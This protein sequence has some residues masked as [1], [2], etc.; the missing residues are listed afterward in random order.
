MR[1]LAFARWV[2]CHRALVAVVIAAITAFFVYQLRHLEVYSEFDDLLPP[3]HAYTA[4]HKKFREKFGGANAVTLAVVVNDGTVFTA[5]TVAKI[6]RITQ[7]VDRLPG[8]DHYHVESLTHRKIRKT[9]VGPG[10]WINT[11]PLVNES[12]L[13][14]TPEELD[15]L[16]ND[17]A[18]SI[19]YGT[20]VSPDFRAAVVTA[21]FHE[22]RI[23]YSG[24]FDGIQKIARDEGDPGHEIHVAGRPMLIGW[25]Y[26]YLPE[27]IYIALFSTAVIVILLLSYF[28]RI[29]GALIPMV[30][31][32]TS[33]IWGL[34][35]VALL[36]FNLDPLGLIVPILL[37][38][39][40][41]SHGVQF[42]ERYFEEYDRLKDVREASTVT[43]A[44]M[45]RPGV[46]GILTDA[47]GILF[48]AVS[49]I[50][51]MVK[52][53]YYCAFLSMSIIVTVLIQAPLLLSV[54]PPPRGN[55]LE[56]KKLTR[57]V[58]TWI[59]SLSAGRGRWATVVV[60]VV[61]AVVSAFYSRHLVIGDV[62][63]GSP[64]LRA[65]SAYNTAE[66]KINER[67]PGSD[68]LFII[69][70]GEKNEVIKE[71]A[72]LKKI[73]EFQQFMELDP[74]AGGSKAL[75]LIV[76]VVNRVLHNND[77]KW[78]RLPPDAYNV[79]GL[80]FAYQ[81]SASIPGAVAEYVDDFLQDANI[82]VYYK[83]HRAS[84]IRAAL[85]RAQEFITKTPVEGIRFRLAGGFIGI[86]AAINEAVA[87]S[88]ELSLTLILVVTFL[89]VAWGYRSF[90]AAILSV[91]VLLLAT[92]ITMAYMAWQGLGLG[93]ETLPVA[94]IG[95]GVGIDYGIYLIDRLKT[96]YQQTQN[97][98][99][100]IRRAITTT[101]MAISFTAT[102][103]IAG[104]IFFYFFS[105]IRF[106]VEMSLL[107]S[108]LMFLNMVG[109]LVLLPTMFYFIRPRF[110]RSELAESSAGGARIGAEQVGAAR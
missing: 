95:V 71:P 2:M 84:T 98:E 47:F 101:G 9:Y 87:Y 102:T 26:A 3:W 21:N 106:Q 61:I 55:Y 96:E 68:Q 13:P 79:G 10:G 62:D 48:I 31:A 12:K 100:A 99:E 94:S 93:I 35:F 73:E 105:N 40:T 46:L 34:G 29:H 19:A 44:S 57:A 18:T 38:A 92:F 78:Q 27:N 72:V 53:A 60:T 4:V 24:I 20:L 28:R 30:S 74:N 14:Q 17:T 45:F 91:S 15:R 7:A 51:L 90:M 76:R 37:I 107:L 83:D 39:R 63:P 64:V 109:A 54:L 43:M 89:L 59:A 52:L 85:D 8:V 82:T 22:T 25:V 58:L 23:D 75:P 33:A 1:E 69:V 36:R 108:L 70:E 104:I 66:R 81:N 42:V 16:R 56:E 77:P 80:L 5:E 50:P 88:N 65:D 49:G 11:E 103:L 6:H 32:V 110:V 97:Y 41:V 86:Y 67:F